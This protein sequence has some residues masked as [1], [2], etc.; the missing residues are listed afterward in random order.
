MLAS[1]ILHTGDPSLLLL[2]PPP[3]PPPH[4]C[5]NYPTCTQV[6][7]KQKLALERRE[8]GG[9]AETPLHRYINHIVN[10]DRGGRR[11]W[12]RGNKRPF[13]QRGGRHWRGK[14]TT[15]ASSHDHW[16]SCHG[17]TDDPGGH[18]EDVKPMSSVPPPPAHPGEEACP[19]G[20]GQP[21]EDGQAT[22][23]PSGDDV[24]CPSGSL[25]QKHVHIRGA[26]IGSRKNGHAKPSRQV[27]VC[28]L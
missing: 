20:S 4:C 23:I 21:M 22:P 24:P 16:S 6:A 28:Q 10:S 25:G 7:K 2:P 27:C 13:A 14:H 11:G 18:D 12:G 26:S 5:R 17:N 3:P 8:T 19:T 15:G 9:V 1:S